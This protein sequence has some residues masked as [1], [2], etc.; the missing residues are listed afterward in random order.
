MHADDGSGREVEVGRDEEGIVPG[1]EILEDGEDA[2]TDAIETADGGYLF[3]TF[4]GV[5]KTDA[6]G[7]SQWV[8]AGCASTDIPDTSVQ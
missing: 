6:A 2:V 8:S 4:T 3:S 5:R 7:T 1:E